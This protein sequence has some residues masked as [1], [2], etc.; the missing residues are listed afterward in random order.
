MPTKSITP[1]KHCYWKDHIRGFK[2]SGLTRAAYCRKQDVDYNL[3]GYYLKKA[4]A[5]SNTAAVAK[6]F[7]H[8]NNAIGDFIPVQVSSAAPSAIEFTLSHPDGV[9]LHWSAQWGPKQVIEFLEHWRATS[10]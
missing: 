9:K 4:K 8:I 7:N 2:K 6:P 10:L 3:L 5:S 1:S